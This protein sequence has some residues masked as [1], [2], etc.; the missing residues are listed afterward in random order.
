MKDQNTQSSDTLLQA[1]DFEEVKIR[2]GETLSKMTQEDEGQSGNVWNCEERL[3]S[4]S[5]VERRS[6]NREQSE[7]D[8]WDG[9]F[10]NGLQR[11][12]ISAC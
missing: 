8:I 6:E 1:W 5:L 10:Q 2:P 9:L 3:I 4:I 12:I 7:M 11:D